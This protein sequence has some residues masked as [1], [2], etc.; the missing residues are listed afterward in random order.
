MGSSVRWFQ[1]FPCSFFP[2]V[3]VIMIFIVCIIIWLMFFSM[4]D[5]SRPMRAGAWSVLLS[6]ASLA[7]FEWS[8]VQTCWLN[9][10]V[11]HLSQLR[12][13]PIHSM[14]PNGLDRKRPA[15]SSPLQTEP[16][17]VCRPSQAPEVAGDPRV[18]ARHS[19][20]ARGGEG[21]SMWPS[22][23]VEEAT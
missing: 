9:E 19:L 13:E 2:F 11:K 17:Q 5:T 1:N 10:A 16:S 8:V 15:T 7:P 18:L 6:S 21:C 12:R 3:A 20:T 14:V 4:H 22:V 23:E